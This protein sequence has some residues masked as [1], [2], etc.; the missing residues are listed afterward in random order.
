MVLDQVQI[1]P[2]HSLRPG[3]QMYWAPAEPALAALSW[4]RL[5]DDGVPI[6]GPRH[7]GPSHPLLG[8]PT[9]SFLAARRPRVP[10]FTVS[11]S[12]FSELKLC[13]GRGPCV[14]TV[15]PVLLLIGSG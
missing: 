7:P 8:S 14:S 1:S 2:A 6:K 15:E 4:P 12:R 13:R 5:T 10:T 3:S 11:P 9:T